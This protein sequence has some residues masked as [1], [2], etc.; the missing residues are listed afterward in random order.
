MYA[1]AS[2]SNPS[3]RKIQTWI[4]KGVRGA[5]A[6]ALVSHYDA[7]LLR[8]YTRVSSNAK[9]A[10]SLPVTLDYIAALRDSPQRPTPRRNDEDYDEKF[11]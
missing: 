6:S 3:G 4:H 10:L 1:R 9:R 7:A 11:S 5:D 8:T 2:V